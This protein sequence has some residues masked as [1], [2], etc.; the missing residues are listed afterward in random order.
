MAIRKIN[1]S[2]KAQLRY[3]RCV[4]LRPISSS[5][6]GTEPS[7]MILPYLEER[8]FREDVSV[9]SRSTSS[10]RFL[11]RIKNGVFDVKM[12]PSQRNSSNDVN[13][14]N[15]NN[16]LLKEETSLRALTWGKKN[17]VTIPLH[18]F[19]AVQKGKGRNGCCGNPTGGI[20]DETQDISRRFRLT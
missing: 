2:G 17:T 3:V 16:S 8:S 15:D 6:Y 1:H 11:D 5:D 19:V 20:Y 18:Q 10:S 4:P 12:K 14:I 9:S 13:T 7:S